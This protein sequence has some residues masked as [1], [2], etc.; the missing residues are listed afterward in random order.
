ME[1]CDVIIVGGGPAGST[2]A[3]ALT[4]AGLDVAV[5]DRSGFPRDKP[6]AGWITPQVASS[7]ELDI[8][9]YRAGRTFQRITGFVT[10][11]IGSS[12]QVVTEYGRPISFGIRRCEFDDYLLRRS[13]AKLRLGST[14]KDIRRD[15]HRWVI[16]DRL[17]APM[18]V[19]AGG[20]FC[21]VARALNPATGRA[22]SQSLVVAQEIEYEMDAHYAQSVPVAGEQP[23]LYF[24]RDLKGYGWCVRKQNVLNLGF[25]RL[26]STGLPKATDE[27]VDFL[28]R[29]GTLPTRP[30]F[31]WRGHAYHVAAHRSRRW[32]GP[33]VLLIGD[34][35]GLAYPQSG[36]G[37]RPAVETGLIAART[38]VAAR[39]RYELE[40]LQTYVAQVHERLGSSRLLSVIA[41]ALPAGVSAP[42]AR[43][44]LRIPGFVRHVVLDRWFLHSSDTPI[45]AAYVDA[46]LS[47]SGAS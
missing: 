45:A 7:L 19:G 32:A 31:P 47:Q 34:A 17:T 16:D 8:E 4:R 37:I 2:C 13:G 1:H 29:Q 15:G 38:I 14:I 21:P 5:L 18:L 6:C 11:T 23:A 30:T 27:F 3:R 42:A 36:E 46:E 39:G 26:D 33:G 25:G 28:V 20:H 24:C 9:E 35:A 40:R 10:G 44:L 22:D 41:H 12:E 43:R